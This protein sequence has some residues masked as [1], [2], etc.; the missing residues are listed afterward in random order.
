MLG[1]LDAKRDWGYAKDYVEA[2]WLM[3][4][5]ETAKDY[6]IATG[7]TYTVRDF[8]ERSFKVVGVDIRW[9]GA[10]DQEVGKNAQSGEVVVRVDPRYYRPAEVELLWGDSSLA[11]K[12]L[13]WKPKTDIDELVKIM[14]KY[15]L[16][17]DDYGGLD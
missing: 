15:D 2:M 8:V 10:G 9:E 17:Y 1:N 6:V 3:L 4:Q 7:K 12:E 16:T 5:Q 11:Q 13:G 14:V